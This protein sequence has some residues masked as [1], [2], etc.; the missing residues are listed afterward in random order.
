MFLNKIS[1]SLSPIQKTAAQGAISTLASIFVWFLNLTAEDR[2]KILKLGEKSEQF[3][4]AVL[5]ALEA[6]PAVA[7]T[8]LDL[9]EFR[10]DLTLWDDLRQFAMLLTPFYEGL[11]DTIMLLGNELMQQAN[12]GY[13][14]IQQAAKGNTAL[15]EI[16]DQLG[17]H[18]LKGSR[19]IANAFIVAPNGTMTLNGIEG[20]RQFKLLS[21]NP[22]TVYKGDAAA[23]KNKVV[24]VGQPVVLGEGWTTITVKSND[25]VNPCVFMVAQ[26]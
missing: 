20:G 8:Q 6:N 23:G 9:V 15:T 1:Q 22:V 19:S 26:E 21:G 4:R 12:M 2:Q 16:A 5:D 10:K 25:P 3:V 7:G 14:L 11:K 17:Q 13:G 24:G 18:Y